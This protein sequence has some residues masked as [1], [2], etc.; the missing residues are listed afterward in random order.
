MNQSSTENATGIGISAYSDPIPQSCGTIQEV[1]GGRQIELRSQHISLGELDQKTQIP[2]HGVIRKFSD[3]GVLTST[4][5]TREFC[6]RRLVLVE[7]DYFNI[8]EALKRVG[9][10]APTEHSA[11]YRNSKI[12]AGRQ[13]SKAKTK[14]FQSIRQ[15]YDTDVSSFG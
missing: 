2:H 12:R 10:W 11:P 3:L 7:D 8:E 5:Y 6:C 15:T 4:P 13:S 14:D 9:S 1:S